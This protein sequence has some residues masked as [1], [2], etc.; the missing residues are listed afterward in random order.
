MLIMS[1]ILLYIKG[2]VLWW[3]LTSLFT[4]VGL[5]KIKVCSSTTRRIVYYYVVQEVT[6]LMFIVGIRDNFLNLILL[7]KGGFAPFHGWMG[8]VISGCFGLSYA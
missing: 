5:T 4:I 6:G 8:K 2:L 1:R 7:I 3:R